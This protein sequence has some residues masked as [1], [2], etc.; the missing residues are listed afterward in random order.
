MI[1]TAGWTGSATTLNADISDLSAAGYT[2][3]WG[4]TPS[5]ATTY[6]INAFGWN[7]TG[8]IVSTPFVDGASFMLGI[9]SGTYP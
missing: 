3:S 1:Y 8:G 5:A 4:L 9:R 6:S 7:L 2:A